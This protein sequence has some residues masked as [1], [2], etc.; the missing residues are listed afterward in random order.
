MCFTHACTL[1]DPEYTNTG[2]SNDPGKVHS[3]K[4]NPYP[5]W[6]GQR[7]HIYIN[8]SF[9]KTLIYKK[10]YERI[11]CYNNIPVYYWPCVFSIQTDERV[12]GGSLNVTLTLSLAQDK[13]LTLLKETLNLCDLLTELHHPCPVSPGHFIFDKHDTVVTALPK[14]TPISHLSPCFALFHTPDMP[15]MCREGTQLGWHQRIKMQRNCF[16]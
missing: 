4:L 7:Y 2:T 10:Q 11:Y 6:I 8:C 9:N 16:V 15:N 12:T 14:V 1:T 13:T 5:L 3:I